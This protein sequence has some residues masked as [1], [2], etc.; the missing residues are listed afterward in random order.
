MIQVPRGKAGVIRSSRLFSAAVVFLALA[1][2]SPAQADSGFQFRPVTAAGT[3]V[4]V[5]VIGREA[6]RRPPPQASVEPHPPRAA[7]PRPRTS[8]AIPSRFEPRRIRSYRTIRQRLRT[9]D[10]FARKGTIPLEYYRQR[11]QAILAGYKP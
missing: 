4:G 3:V 5:Q 2:A 1:A 6:Q 7:P 8:A 11:Q 10:R 9:L